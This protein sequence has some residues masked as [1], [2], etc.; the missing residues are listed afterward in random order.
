MLVLITHIICMWVLVCSLVNEMNETLWFQFL[1]KF[2]FLLH[3]N[4]DIFTGTKHTHTHSHAFDIYESINLLKPY[5][6]N[7]GATHWA[8]VQLYGPS[9]IHKNEYLLTSFSF[10]W[11][12]TNKFLNLKGIFKQI[13]MKLNIIFSLIIFTQTLEGRN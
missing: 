7:C 1:F 9:P 12:S 13:E 4:Q 10:L 2:N 11:R 8:F 5:K 6:R 3:F